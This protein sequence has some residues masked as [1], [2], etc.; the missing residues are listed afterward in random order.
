MD[1]GPMDPSG[2]I[3]PHERDRPDDTGRVAILLPLLEMLRPA[4]ALICWI[5]SEPQP[6]PTMPGVAIVTSCR[7]DELDGALGRGLGNEVIWLRGYPTWHAVQTLGS[8]LLAQ[9]GSRSGA[10]PVVIVEGSRSDAAPLERVESTKEGVR[11]ALEDLGPALGL[12]GTVIWSATGR[13]FGAWIPPAAA[14]RLRPWLDRARMVLEPLRTEHAARV[15]LDA[16]TFALFEDLDQSQRDATA[17]VR[18]SRFRLGTRAVRLARTVLR[19]D[20]VFRPPGAVLARQSTVDEWRARLAA[21]HRSHVDTGAGALRVTFVLPELR[22]SG[23]ALVVLQ[24]VNELRLLG[25]DA[26]VFARRGRRDRRREVF[27]WRLQVSPTV[28]PEE[29]SLVKGMAATDIVVATHWT[30]AA[31]VRE[32]LAAGRA[33]HAAYFVQDYEPWFFAEDDAPARERVKLTYELIEPKIVTSEW[34]RELLAADGYESKVVPLGLDLGFFYPRPVE[35]GA[36]PVVL[37]MARPRTP[38]RAFDFVVATLAKVHEAMPDA[39]IVL[40]GE[41][42]DSLKLPFP[43]RGAGVITDHDELAR[44]YSSARVHFDGSD[45][46]AFGL[47]ALE[48]MACGAVSVLTDAGGVSEYARDQENCLLVPPRDVDASAGAILRLLRDA[49]LV[50]RMRDAGFATS[51]ELSLKRQARDTLAVLEALRSSAEAP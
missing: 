27:R 36:R 43:Y 51:R 13:G 3:A 41:Q 49:P 1:P 42:I 33:H 21:E 17:V 44:L 16:R 4:T 19:K 45:F 5:D 15:A 11:L 14:A 26:R 28:L 35:R 12:D 8:S 24:L 20:A 48:A 2:S 22:L 18:S 32:L 7:A 37:A 39:E 38:R 47:P 9:A 40:F 23:G 30:T 34:L 25:V 6:D 31:W 50:A 46:Q 29:R 10:P